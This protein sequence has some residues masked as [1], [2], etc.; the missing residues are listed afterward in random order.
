MK[1]VIQYSK[2]KPQHFNGSD[3]IPEYDND[4]LSSQQDAIF[5]LMKDGVYRTLSK[6][7]KET[8]Y[9]E[10]SIS[11]QLRHFR[12]PR[13]GSHIVNKMV[14]GNRSRGLFSYQLLLNKNLKYV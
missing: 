13:F 8:G 4:R 9:P 5:D 1:K 10:P 12:K 6:I 14:T 3:Y 7:K 11:A 2:A